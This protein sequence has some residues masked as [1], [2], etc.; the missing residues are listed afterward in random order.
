MDSSESSNLGGF[1]GSSD[2]QDLSPFGLDGPI[3][4]LEIELLW[5]DAVRLLEP[6]W[7]T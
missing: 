7:T 6:T 5:G 3:V 1:L 2:A 4:V